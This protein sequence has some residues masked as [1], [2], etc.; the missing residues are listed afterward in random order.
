MAREFTGGEITERWPTGRP[1]WESRYARKTWSKVVSGRMARNGQSRTSH[2]QKKN[3]KVG[4]REQSFKEST[5][6]RRV[7]HEKRV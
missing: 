2:T 6:R 7:I 3:S 1:L 5:H 4:K